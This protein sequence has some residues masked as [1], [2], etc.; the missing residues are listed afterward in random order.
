VHD[1]DDLV[2]GPD[3]VEKLDVTHAFSGSVDERER[4]PATAT[5][6]WRLRVAAVPLDVVVKQVLDEI[7]IAAQH[8]LERASRELDVR[9]CHAQIVPPT[10]VRYR[11]GVTAIRVPL[12]G[13]RPRKFRGLS[14]PMLVDGCW[15][16]PKPRPTSP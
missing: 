15:A 2:A 1:L 6:A 9:L 8:P 10:E 13:Q 12:E 14:P 3:D 5:R 11:V 4:L 16:G 7:E